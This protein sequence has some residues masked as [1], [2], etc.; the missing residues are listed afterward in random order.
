MLNRKI[1]DVSL[2]QF[3]DEKLNEMFLNGEIAQCPKCKR[4]HELNIPNAK[5]IYNL[6]L[7]DDCKNDKNILKGWLK[8]G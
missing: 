1:A 7:C 6:S 2:Y 8:N 4:Y 5:F 3:T